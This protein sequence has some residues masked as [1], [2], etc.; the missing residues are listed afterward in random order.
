MPQTSPAAT[1]FTVPRN[2]GPSWSIPPV[3]APACLGLLDQFQTE[4]WYYVGV[5]EA[6]DE[7]FSI[8][9]EILRSNVGR[10]GTPLEAVV[11]YIGIGT[12]SDN[13][14]VSSLGLNFGVSTDRGTA[15]GFTIPP[16]TDHCYDADFH[17]W[18]TTMQVRATYTGGADDA[19][20]GTPGARYTVHANGLDAQLAPVTADFVLTNQRGMVLEGQS[21]YVGPH[22]PGS[23]ELGGQ[24]SSYEFAEPLLDVESG[25]ITLGD[26]SYAITGGN[27]WLDRQVITPIA[28]PVAELPVWPPSDVAALAT[29]LTDAGTTSPLYCGDWMTIKLD[30]GPTIVLATF[31][32]PAAE[33]EQQWFTGTATGRPPLGGVGTIYFPPDETSLNGGLGIIGAHADIKTVITDDVDFDLNVFDPND[34]ESSPHWQSPVSGNTYATAWQ[35]RFAA[36]LRAMQ[37]PGAMYVRALVDGCE[38]D[39]LGNF[40]Y[41]GAALVYADKALTQR[42]GTAYVE[43]MG[44]N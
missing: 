11:G 2:L 30:C 32:Q 4:W 3:S 29:V 20:V 27:L 17:D 21:G 44:F 13:R 38:V 26:R 35:L 5:V 19:P 31:W 7:Q 39:M 24:L 42:I 34:A 16:V 23:V 28:P 8:Q 25:S 12:Q 10:P 40:F 22:M 37:V 1:W 41:E 15:A 18:T 43:Q 36:R 14:Y 33:G 9:I 6:A